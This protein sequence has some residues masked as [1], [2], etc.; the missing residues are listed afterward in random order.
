MMK[1]TLPEKYEERKV[2]VDGGL[3]FGWDRETM[4]EFLTDSDISDI[5]IL[6]GDVLEFD[7]KAKKFKTNY[8]NWFLDRNGSTESFADYCVR[9]R[10]KT[11]EYVMAYKKEFK[12]IIFAPVLSSEPTAGLLT[13]G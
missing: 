4:I 9:S 3:G 8:D 1:K 12:R 2:I 7:D 5:A 10:Q 6:G 13:L 11:L